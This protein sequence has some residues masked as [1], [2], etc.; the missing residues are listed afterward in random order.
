MLDLRST[1]ELF[2]ISDV[3]L[4]PY[5]LSYGSGVLLLGMTFGVHVVATSTGGMDE[6]LEGYP[7]RTLLDG[8]DTE[9]IVRGI[10]RAVTRIERPSG[11]RQFPLP[12]LDWRVVAGKA[13]RS[14]EGIPPIAQ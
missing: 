11:P 1:S 10:E 9:S 4:L 3:L 7:A 2:E 8:A 5:L 12:D 14:L 6:Y 13:L